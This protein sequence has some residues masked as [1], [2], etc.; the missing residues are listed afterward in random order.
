M[1]KKAVYPIHKMGKRL[2][3]EEYEDGSIRIAP[4]SYQ[5]IDDLMARQETV[6][7]LI[8]SVTEQCYH[9]MLP[10]TE[11]LRAFWVEVS[12]EYGLDKHFES[13]PFSYDSRT[14]KITKRPAPD[15]EAP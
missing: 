1:V 2:G 11:G 7:N 5:K 10:I 8:K 15:K 3:Y 13:T 12:E 9:L 4:V 6:A 14:K